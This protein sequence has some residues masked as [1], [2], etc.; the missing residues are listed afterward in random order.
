MASVDLKVHS[1]FHFTDDIHFVDSFYTY[2][3]KPSHLN[4][5]SS[6]SSF[7]PT[8]MKGKPRHRRESYTFSPPKSRGFAHLHFSPGGGRSRVFIDLKGIY[9]IPQ[10]SRGK[11]LPVK[12][13]LR[14]VRLQAGLKPTASWEGMVTAAFTR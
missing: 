1:N 5:C 9:F 2:K 6:A 7:L 3:T 11:R 14:T 12:S 8:D 13:L 10:V 4:N